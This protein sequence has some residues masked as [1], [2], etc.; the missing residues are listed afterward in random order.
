MINTRYIE[1]TQNKF[2]NELYDRVSN[3]IEWQDVCG[4]NLDNCIQ[5]I[6][7]M[8]FKFEFKNEILDYFVEEQIQNLRTSYRG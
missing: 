7:N 6:N 8:Y 1:K 4:F 5:E 2:K 3:L